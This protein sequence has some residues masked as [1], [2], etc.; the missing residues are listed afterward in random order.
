MLGVGCRV[1]GFGCRVDTSLVPVR[2]RVRDVVVGTFGEDHVGLELA[3]RRQL[4]LQ[5]G[6][7]L[8]IAAARPVARS[9]LQTPRLDVCAGFRCV[10]SRSLW[11]YG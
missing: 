8:E 2:G 1:S 3:V 5:R 7:P 6:A 9:N 10:T 11:F 4:L